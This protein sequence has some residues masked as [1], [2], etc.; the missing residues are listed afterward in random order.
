VQFPVKPPAL[1]EKGGDSSWQMRGS[2]FLDE[3]GEVPPLTQLFFPRV[4]QEKNFEPAAGEDTLFV[5]SSNKKGA[6][7]KVPLAC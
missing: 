1:E 4:F 2:Y 5:W 7:G 6:N 3:I